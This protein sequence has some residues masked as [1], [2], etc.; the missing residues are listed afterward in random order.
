M[1]ERCR[2]ELR[3]TE[4]VF[5]Y[6]TETTDAICRSLTG[7]VSAR[8]LV[9]LTGS[10]TLPD[11]DFQ[12]E[13]TAFAVL[14]WIH[15]WMIKCHL[16]TS[17]HSSSSDSDEE[18]EDMSVVS[19]DDTGED[20]GGSCASSR[21][22]FRLKIRRSSRSARLVDP[23]RTFDRRWSVLVKRLGLDRGKDED[24]LGDENDDDAVRV[25]TRDVR[26][27]LDVDKLPVVFTHRLS[28]TIGTGV[29]IEASLF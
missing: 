6:I 3:L 16:H 28:P 19:G 25:L 7:Q 17:A 4:A 13:S 8:L 24:G 20:T 29:D 5:Q 27:E 1:G 9:N 14:C 11:D 21:S 2:E 18:D 26:V 12:C 15:D 23:M 10:S 22:E